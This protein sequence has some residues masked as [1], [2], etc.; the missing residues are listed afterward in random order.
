MSVT[1]L[2]RLDPGERIEMTIPHGL[3]VAEVVELAVPGAPTDMVRVLVVGTDRTHVVP[4][5]MWRRVRPHPQTQIVIRVLPAGGDALRSVLT[6][7][8]AIAALTVGQIVT[9]PFG[10]LLGSLAAGAVLAGG[11]L[12]V[13]ALI[14]VRRPS[15]A[16]DA[17]IYSISGMRN[18]LAPGAPVP[19]VLGRMRWAPPYAA[20]PWTRA[21]GLRRYVTAAFCLGYGPLQ[22][23]DIRIGDTPID[24]YKDLQYEVRNGYPDDDPL[25]LY[26]TQVLEEPLSVGLNYNKP[27]TRFTSPDVDRGSV[28]VTFSQGLYAVDK[29]GRQVFFIVGFGLRYRKAGTTTW[30]EDGFTVGA[31]HTQ[32]LVNTYEWDFPERAQWEVE[33]VRTSLDYDILD[34]YEYKA[35]SRSDWTALRGFRPEYVHNFSKNCAFLAVDI[36]GTDQLNGALDE[37]NCL[38][39]SILPD[40]DAAT[41]TWIERPTRNPAS[42]FRHVL[43]GA[44]TVR[45]VSAAEV[46]DMEDWHTWCVSKGLT[47]DRVHADEASV[48]DV[49]M[50]IAAAGRATP[51]DRGSEWGVVIDRIMTLVRGHVSPRNSRDFKGR[52]T[53]ARLPDAF[54]VRFPDESNGYEE[55][56]RIVPIPGF[57]GEPQIIEDLP[58]PGVTVPD[59]V[60]REAR[61]RGYELQHR[62]DTYEVVQDFEHLLVRRGDLVRLSHDV[63]DREQVTGRVQSVTGAVVLLDEIV[64]MTAGETY[65]C[66]FRRADG[67]SLLRTVE[68]QARSTRALVLTGSGDLPAPGDLAMVGRASEETLACIVKG[69][70][71]REDLSAKLT[72]IDA[73]PEIETLTDAEVAPAWD[74]R[75]GNVVGDSTLPPAVPVIT[76]VLSG[77][78][79]GA[80][81]VMVQLAPGAGGAAPAT[82]T[83][84]HRLEGGS[85]WTPVTVLAV[86]GYAAVTG[87]AEGVVIDLRARATS[88]NGYASDW[89]QIVA[90]E[91]ATSR[92]QQAETLRI[93]LRGSNWIYAWTL[94]AGE[95][96]VIPAAGVRIR[97]GE[98]AG[99]GWSDLTPLHGGLLTVAPWEAAAPPTGT[100]YTIG[101]ASVT[102][103]G[104]EGTP[105]LLTVTE[106]MMGAVI[107]VKDIDGET[108]AIEYLS[109]VTRG[110]QGIHFV[111]TSGNKAARNYAFGKAS[112][113]FVGPILEATPDA[114]RLRHLSTYVETGVNESAKMTVFSVIRR[115]NPEVGNAYFWG[116]YQ[117]PNAGSVGPATLFGAGL[118]SGTPTAIY[119]H[120]ARWNTNTSAMTNGQCTLALSG[121]DWQLIVAL[122]DTDGLGRNEL[123]NRTANTRN[124]SN[125]AAGVHRIIGSA[126]LRIGSA[127]SAVYGDSYVAYWQAHNVILTN[128]EIDAVVADIRTNMLRHGITV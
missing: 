66:R 28:D 13:N 117:S 87:Y 92:L 38:T 105:I 3:T 59:L 1:I 126:P 64:T 113:S 23:E 46:K 112:G 4:P 79:A 36:R 40:W 110:L 114:M 42:H 91:V 49:L 57:A 52:R 124:A 47:Y 85:S 35:S 17:P 63:L 96:D 33:L 51:Q 93:D 26:T 20:K 82:Y 80:D 7:A 60:W 32:P 75:V 94:T 121:S 102:A 73:A 67:S 120:A 70:E 58:L 2:Q 118:Y 54:R 30:I 106:D 109:P 16:Q 21:V 45:P 99:L 98:G 24:Q 125:S 48:I 55:A 56:E 14:P 128:S 61:R 25:T 69:V 22:I 50:D 18:V 19:R 72:L 8:V 65:A 78:A 53:L 6:V 104:I 116:N 77:A 5:Q 71:L 88:A 97:Y 10:P 119:L 90:H 103:D 27:Q 123:R 62:L 86:S 11:T 107:I 95:G 127:R 76:G 34:Q 41:Q 12:L 15:E 115:P 39:T 9:G 83:V 108:D 43:T 122:I 74:G 89:S 29:D 68:T 111:N 84:E 100:D 44:A 31:K 37:V 81:A 101:I